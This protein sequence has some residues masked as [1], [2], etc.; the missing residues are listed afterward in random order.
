MFSQTVEYALRAM[1]VLAKVS[2]TP[3]R[4]AEIAKSA[5]IPPAYLVKILQSLGRAGLVTSQR[6]I[7]GGIALSKVPAE[8]T[9]LDVVNAMEPAPRIRSCPL[10]LKA[11][12]L[13]LCLLHSKMDSVLEN[14]EKAFSTTALSE[15][16]E[17]KISKQNCSFPL[18]ASHTPHQHLKT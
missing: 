12:G 2:P 4:T 13:K 18:A 3:K 14:M 6:G 7:N 8:I 15:V 16:I 17:N 10:G 5:K 11:H 1:V 9:I